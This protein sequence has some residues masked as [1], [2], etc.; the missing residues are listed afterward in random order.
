MV[1]EGRG[2]SVTLRRYPAPAD[3][4][5]RGDRTESAAGHRPL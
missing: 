2:W 4:R 5:L 1:L 3:T